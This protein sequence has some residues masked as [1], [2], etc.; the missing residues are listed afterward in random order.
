MLWDWRIAIPKEERKQLFVSVWIMDRRKEITRNL[1]A[2]SQ[3]NRKMLRFIRNIIAHQT[4]HKFKMLDDVYN[5]IDSWL[6][7]LFQSWGAA[8]ATIYNI[9][10]SR[11]NGNTTN[12]L[13]DLKEQ[14]H[15]LKK[16]KE[17]KI[18][19]FSNYYSRPFWPLKY[20]YNKI[21]KHMIRKHQIKTYKSEIPRNNKIEVSNHYLRVTNT[22]TTKQNQ[23][24]YE[25][26]QKYLE[27][28][29]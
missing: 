5:K 26:N 22:K 11:R 7:G 29:I 10:T 2:Y 25:K 13:I 6:P 9:D 28:N 21:I 18:N 14:W 4:D 20:E 19:I 3:S 8:K 27:M 16:R 1:E 17:E 24:T 12:I 23:N 15:Q